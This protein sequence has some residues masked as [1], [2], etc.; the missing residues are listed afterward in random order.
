MRREYTLSEIAAVVGMT[1]RNV[2]AYRS[3]GLIRPPRV[4]G[5]VGYYG[6]DH[7]AQLRL[8]QAL[9]GRGL[10]LAVVRQLVAR[11]A[12]QTELARMVRDELQG[13]GPVAL[14]PFVL[15]ELERAEPG[16]VQR[17]VDVGLGNRTET[18][19]ESDAAF[20]ALSN[21]VVSLGVPPVAAART[22][23]QAAHGARELARNLEPLA[24]ADGPAPSRDTA[25]QSEGAIADD[26]VTGLVELATTAF[27]MALTH[28]LREQT[29]SAPAR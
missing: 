6:L 11:G 1:E 18:G 5:R 16:L 22:S 20:L 12:A 3:R 9:V 24:A 10:S 4:R 15:A 25:Q 17:M 14:S 23:L 28:H 19:F 27:R 29:L 13:G 21:L 26:V 2:R 7:L 8:V